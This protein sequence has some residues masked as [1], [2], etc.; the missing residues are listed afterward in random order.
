MHT[1]CSAETFENELLYI[2]DHKSG[3]HIKMATG[4]VTGPFLC[5]IHLYYVVNH[6]VFRAVP[7][8]AVPRKAA[9]QRPATK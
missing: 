5:Y 9:V 2:L 8:R 1:R 3:T 4:T 6:P 7:C